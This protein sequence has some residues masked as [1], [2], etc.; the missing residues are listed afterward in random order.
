MVSSSLPEN[1]LKTKAYIEAIL[2][3]A[4]GNVN[5]GQIAEVLNISKA[6]VERAIE[7][8]EKEY[9]EPE[10]GRGLRIQRHRGRVQLTTAAQI[11]PVIERFIGLESR[12]RL[13]HASLET[14]AIILYKQPITK[15][16]IEAIRGVN[17]DGVV[18]SLL[19]KGLVQEIGRANTPGRPFLYS[20]TPELLQHLGLNS[21]EDLPAFD[22]NNGGISG[23]SEHNSR[24]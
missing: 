20:S 13:S 16:Q 17:C 8:L 9:S 18:K 1:S 3:I 12:A 4:P 10:S 19:R 21:V 15:P 23:S 22:L 5:P 24:N 7:M 11:A 14:M 6:D 2:F